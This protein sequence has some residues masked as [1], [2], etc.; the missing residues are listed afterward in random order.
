[1]GLFAKMEEVSS[2][3]GDGC[4]MRKVAEGMGGGRMVE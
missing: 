1:M 2:G 3:C 4:L